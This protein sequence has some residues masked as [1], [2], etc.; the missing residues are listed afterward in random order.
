MVG[1]VGVEMVLTITFD[2]PGNSGAI[3]A[4]GVPTSKH[5]VIFKYNFTV[6]M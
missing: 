3:V 1:I 4:T 6:K 5:G 2:W